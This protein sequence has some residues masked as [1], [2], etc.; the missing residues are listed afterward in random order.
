MN[1]ECGY[2]VGFM[3]DGSLSW[4]GLIVGIQCADNGDTVFTINEMSWLDDSLTGRLFD[5]NPDIDLT[6]LFYSRA[7]F[8][9]FMRRTLEIEDKLVAAETVA[10][11]DQIEAT[12]KH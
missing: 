7:A 10:I 5:V 4:Q 2:C 1:N 3:A 11:L 6:C 12:T 9:V 8:D